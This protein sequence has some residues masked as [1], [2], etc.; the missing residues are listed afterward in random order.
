MGANPRYTA[1]PVKCI[2][3]GTNVKESLADD[4]EVFRGGVLGEPVKKYDERR[5]HVVPARLG[6]QHRCL[7]QVVHH[8]EIPVEINKLI[9]DSC[10][11]NLSSQ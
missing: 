9:L 5:V 4:S 11:R 10:G 8:S 6:Q 2:N 3:R 7:R 1:T